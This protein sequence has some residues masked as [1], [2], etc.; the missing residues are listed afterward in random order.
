[1][2]LDVHKWLTEDLGFSDDEAKE[3]APKFV[4]ERVQKL[5]GG[6][7]RQSDYSRMAN[8]LNTAKSELAAANERLNAEYA[9]FAIVKQNDGQITTKMRS[10]LEAAQAQVL[11]LTQHVSRI[12]TDAGLDPAKALEGIEQVKPVET[13]A[14]PDLTGYVKAEDFSRAT[15]SLADMMLEYTPTLM[16]LAHE[17]QSLFGAPL[18]ARDLV[19]ELR[20]RVSDKRNQKSTDLRAIWEEQHKVADKRAAVEQARIDGLVAAAEQRGREAALSESVLPGQVNAPG[21]HAPIFGGKPRESALKRPQPESSIHAAA[22]AFR[23]G[24]YRPQ[25]ATKKT[26]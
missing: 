22:S 4:G 13:P 11:A 14:A 3:L 5:E 1:M 8:E 19:K 10:D 17:H 9:E 6:Y 26:A 18:D 20:A 25:G 7:L 16:S 24:K 15:G 21:S 12:A 2:A 23:T